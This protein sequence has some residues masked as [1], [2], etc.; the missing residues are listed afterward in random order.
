M[1]IPQVIL[2]DTIKSTFKDA[3][4]KLTG[5]RKRDLMAKI[6]EDYFDSSARIAET[7][8]PLGGF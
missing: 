3:A 7:S 6:T 2:T 5:S 4:K 1:E 8:I